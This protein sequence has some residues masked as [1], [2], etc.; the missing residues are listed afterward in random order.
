MLWG[1]VILLDP[2]LSILLEVLQGWLEPVFVDQ[3]LV[4]L[5]PF[6]QVVT[7]NKELLKF[8]QESSTVIDKFIKSLSAKNGIFSEFTNSL[9]LILR[10]SITRIFHPIAHSKLFSELFSFG[11]D[12]YVSTL[13][14]P[15]ELLVLTALQFTYLLRELL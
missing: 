6:E 15:L 3:D 10:S 8:H 1:S 13:V 11:S 9:R 14:P 4:D 7:S 2:E 5:L 12:G